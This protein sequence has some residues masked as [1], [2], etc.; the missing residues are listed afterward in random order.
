MAGLSAEEMGARLARVRGEV[1]RACAR[2]GRDPAGVTLIAVSKGHPAAAVAALCGPALGQR[3]FGENYAQEL[4]DKAREPALAGAGLRWHF[5]GALQRNKVRLVVGTAA[6]I[7]TV[8]GAPLIEAL[9]ARARQQ[10]VQVDCL[11]EVNLGGEAQKGGCAPGEIAGLLD[12]ITG[13]GGALRCLGLMCIPPAPPEGLGAE[14]EAEASRPYFRRLRGL[15]SEARAVTRPH[16]ELRELSMGMSHDFG[17]AI[18]EGATLVRVGTAI[19]GPRQP[20]R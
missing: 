13:E 9:S 11:L 3:D 18:E 6:L 14:A 10:G 4:R 1:D 8:D 20:R 5:I 12:A 7:H 15:L 17:V 16:V 2:A 19:F